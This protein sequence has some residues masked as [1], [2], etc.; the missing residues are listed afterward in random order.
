MIKIYLC[1]IQPKA[2]V[3]ASSA[4]AKAPAL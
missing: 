4:K 3:Q 1:I 2:G